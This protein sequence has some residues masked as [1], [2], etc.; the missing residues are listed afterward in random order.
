MTK[1]S[2][3]NGS[4]HSPNLVYNTSNNK[5]NNRFKVLIL[6]AIK[7]FS[8]GIGPY[9]HVVEFLTIYK[10]FHTEIQISGSLV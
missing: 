2:E 4:K 3:P 8:F 5:N 10:I 7:H 9:I 1:G 6:Q